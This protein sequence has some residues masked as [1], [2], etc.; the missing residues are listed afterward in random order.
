MRPIIPACFAALL[1]FG[2]CRKTPDPIVRER[3][4]GAWKLY[5]YGGD[6]PGLSQ[7][8]NRGRP[9]PGSVDIAWPLPIGPLRRYAQRR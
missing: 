6:K 9:L 7:E 2:S 1:L 4:L 3:L 8:Y 5:A